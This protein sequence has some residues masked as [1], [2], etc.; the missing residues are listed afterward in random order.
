MVTKAEGVTEKGRHAEHKAR[1]TFI[2]RRVIEHVVGRH[3]ASKDFVRIL[4]RENRHFAVRID[5]FN[6]VHMRASV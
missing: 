3:L 5:P 6:P 4:W 2:A 1:S